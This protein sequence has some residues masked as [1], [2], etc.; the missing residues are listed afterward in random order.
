[1]NINATIIAQG[2]TF[3]IFVWLTMKFVWPT[4]KQAMDERESRIADGLAA[5]EK[6]V[7]D[8][9]MA[10]SEA[11]QLLDQ[12]KN[13]AAELLNQAN[14]RSAEIVEEARS[15]ARAQGERMMATA[16][17]QIDQDVARAREQ[18]RQEVAALAVAGAGKVLG[19]EIDAK[20]HADLLDKVANEL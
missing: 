19:R 1:M 4:I 2:I 12:A 3:A 8:L 6:G 10:R 13:Q 16:R 20:A 14:K 9:D 18:L 11:K 17:A 5:A 7:R 15:E